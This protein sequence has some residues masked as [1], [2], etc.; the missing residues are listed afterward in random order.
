MQVPRGS[1]YRLNPPSTTTVCAVT[2]AA[3]A[4]RNTITS[5][6]SSGLQGRFSNVR[7]TAAALRSGGQVRVQSV[8][9]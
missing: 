2:I 9:T 6:M 5:A 3:P 1:R 8:S 7:Y 4:H